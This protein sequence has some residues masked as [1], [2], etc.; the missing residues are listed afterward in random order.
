[1]VG[2]TGLKE[3]R[4]KLFEKDKVLRDLQKCERIYT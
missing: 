4:I 3:N 1:M 2:Y